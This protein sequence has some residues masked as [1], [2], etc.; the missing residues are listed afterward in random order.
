MK[1]ENAIVGSTVKAKQIFYIE[2]LVGIC[3]EILGISKGGYIIVGYDKMYSTVLHTPN[4][5]YDKYHH[6]FLPSHIKLAK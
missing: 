1:I 5:D 3:G 2:N 6:Y 4:E